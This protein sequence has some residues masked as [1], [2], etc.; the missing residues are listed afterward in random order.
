MKDRLG[1]VYAEE[2]QEFE[3]DRHNLA[4]MGRIVTIILIVAAIVV[5]A[6]WK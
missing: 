6:M 3:N 2:H 5:M 4:Y 1:E